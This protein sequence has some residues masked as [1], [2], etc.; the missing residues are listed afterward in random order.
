M[1][2]VRV[3]TVSRARLDVLLVSRAAIV[4]RELV[5]RARLEASMSFFLFRS[6][7]ISLRFFRMSSSILPVAMG[8]VRVRGGVRGRV[9]VRVRVGVRVGARGS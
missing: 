6:S 3:A 8:R 7:A 2:L 4:S 1:L 9:R 5:S